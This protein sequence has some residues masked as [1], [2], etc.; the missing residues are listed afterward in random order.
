MRVKDRPQCYFDV[1]LNR[2]PGKSHQHQQEL[3]TWPS[4][5]GFCVTAN[6]ILLKAYLFK[7]FSLL[8][9]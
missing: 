5:K 7:Y 4:L 3:P 2:E 9:L 1:E 8:C 6:C